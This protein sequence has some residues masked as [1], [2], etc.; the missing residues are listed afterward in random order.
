MGLICAGINKLSCFPPLP[1]VLPSQRIR[2]IESTLDLGSIGVKWLAES[3]LSNS[4]DP[5]ILDIHP[6]K[7]GHEGGWYEDRRR[8]GLHITPEFTDAIELNN[9]LAW[10]FI[11]GT[12]ELALQSVEP[13]FASIILSINSKNE[14]MFTL[15]HQT[16][17]KYGL[18]TLP[19]A[20]L[21]RW[22]WY[23]TSI[24]DIR[25]FENLVSLEFYKLNFTGEYTD[26]VP[27]L[28]P[29]DEDLN[30]DGIVDIVTSTEDYYGI[31]IV[32]RSTL[33][34]YA[35]LFDFSA[36]DLSITQKAIPILSSKQHNPTL[37]GN[38][39]LTIGYGRGGQFPLMFELN[40]AQ[41]NDINLFKLFV[42]TCPT[43]PERYPRAQPATTR[44]FE[45]IPDT[46]PAQD[47]Q[48]ECYIS[49]GHTEDSEMED[50]NLFCAQLSGKMWDEVAIKRSRA[51]IPDSNDGRACLKAI[52][53][54]GYMWSKYRHPNIVEI[55]GICSEIACGLYYLHQ[56]DTVNVLVSYDGVAKLH[57]FGTTSM[58]HYTLEF[59]GGTGTRKYTL[60]W[61]APEV[62]LDEDVGTPAD[63]YAL[64]MEVMTGSPPFHYINKDPAVSV[65]VCMGEKPRRP[66]AHI[67]HEGPYGD[68]LWDLLQRCWETKLQDA[69]QPRKPST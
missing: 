42:S 30:S 61:A 16:L 46:L 66:E 48:S 69:R 28:V 22:M 1:S 52:A 51:H 58:K 38:T 41:N 40:E 23:L 24:P 2:D 12:D 19:A 54:E 39:S 47:D 18:E 32:N 21:C 36:T 55:Y 13:E 44:R 25:P 68:K 50:S 35:Y 64:G 7:Y 20:A 29:E 8:L 26:G 67:P 34:L 31:K 65:A 9:P 14:V 53:K 43:E 60:R 11:D 10:R 6:F 33:D 15:S 62:L 37:A 57:D 5:D 45:D 49:N 4:R 27:I 17:A 3:F 63:V 56:M 59:T